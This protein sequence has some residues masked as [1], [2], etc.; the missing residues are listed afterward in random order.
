[1]FGGGIMLSLGATF[2][3]CGLGL[4][5]FAPF[6]LLGLLLSVR[7][8]VD[9][10]GDAWSLSFFDLF[11]ITLAQ[12]IGMSVFVF[13][14]LFF[15]MHLR[16]IWR[17]PLFV[18]FFFLLLWGLF[19]L[20]Y[21]ISPSPVL[22]TLYEV[23]RMST[24]FF[25][26]ALSFFTIKTKKDFSF[27]I[28]IICLSSFIPFL[29]CTWQFFTGV[30]YTDVAFDTPR[31]FGTFTH[32]NIL[33]TYLVA[34]FA[35]S[36]LGFFISHEAKLGRLR[37][38]CVASGVFSL[39]FLILT[40]TRVGWITLLVFLLCISL[41]RFRR[42][43][44][45]TLL[46]PFLLI[47]LSS[48]VQERV[49][50]SFVLSPDSSIGWRLSL[51][52]DTINETISGGRVF[53]GHG[54]NT[55]SQVAEGL[56]GNRFGSTDPHNEFVRA[57]VEGGAIGLSVF[58]LFHFFAFRHL[59]RLYQRTKKDSFVQTSVLIV[60]CLFV[61]LFFASLSDHIFRST[62]LQWILWSL[63]GGLSSLVVRQSPNN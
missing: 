61:A 23:A 6:A 38:L 20:F 33:S 15:L 11:S 51:W 53:F 27:L 21:S 39:V 5:F 7:V 8:V 10:V 16:T 32:P 54:L 45:P 49:F 36:V 25:I 13:M 59:V 57:F 17:I 28:A 47:L 42:L 1:L 12:G 29:V 35:V 44:L 2:L 50:D 52:S 19:T 14:L 22:T 24:I 55:F 40:F 43:L 18:S 4:L 26:F 3:F 58:L 41:V 60:T 48:S 30:G 46:L 63:I 37:V 62:P 31:I 34:V 56:R 9:S